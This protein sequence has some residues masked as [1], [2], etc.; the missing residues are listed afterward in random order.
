VDGVQVFPATGANLA[1]ALSSGSWHVMEYRNLDM[2][3]WTSLYLNSYAAYMP[4]VNHGDIVLFQNQSAA[5]RALART[6]VGA[7]VGLNL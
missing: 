5:N 1:L 2:S 4:Q 6:L 7:S 3:T